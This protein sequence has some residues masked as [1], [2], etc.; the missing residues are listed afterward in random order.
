M[1]AKSIKQ[2]ESDG[3]L[4]AT[5]LLRLNLIQNLRVVVSVS[6]K[7]LLATG[8]YQVN[9]PVVQ[10]PQPSFL[11][12][13][14]SQKMKSFGYCTLDFL[15][16]EKTMPKRIKVEGGQTSEEV[17][18]VYQRCANPHDHKRLL[19]L[20]MAQQGQWTMQQIAQAIGKGRAKERA[21][22]KGLSTRRP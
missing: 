11:S 18:A 20:Q 21:L 9:S 3:R 8:Q 19:A 22:D 15:A 10:N 6:L 5:N 16:M 14:K 7:G 17:D 13:A 1:L 4:L 2:S 12:H